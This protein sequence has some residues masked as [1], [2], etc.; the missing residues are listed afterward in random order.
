[1]AR[2]EPSHPNADVRMR[3]F[4]QRTTVADALAWIDSNLPNFGELGVEEVSLLSAAG[5]VLARD[6]VSSV[7]VPGFARAMMDGFAV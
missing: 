1:M 7:N 5:R 4:A 2:P 3:G 6:V